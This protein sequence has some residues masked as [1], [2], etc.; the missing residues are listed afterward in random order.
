V[1]YITKEVEI[2][3][4]EETVLSDMDSSTVIEY[5]KD[6]YGA[7]EILGELD[8][9]EVLEHMID[10]CTAA[11]ILDKISSDDVIEYLTRSRNKHALAALLRQIATNLDVE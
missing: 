10:Q 9:D 11:T 5:A 2:E 8:A 7:S 6:N 3:L 1:I 4:D